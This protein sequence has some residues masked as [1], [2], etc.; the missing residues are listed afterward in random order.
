[1]VLVHVE[2][3]EVQHYLCVVAVRVVGMTKA[4]RS[5][6][7][8]HIS[9][10]LSSSN[11]YLCHF[12]VDIFLIL[13]N[14]NF[15]LP[16]EKKLLRIVRVRKHGRVLGRVKGFPKRFFFEGRAHCIANFLLLYCSSNALSR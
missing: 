1:M 5:F 13:H 6:M 11:L 15:T 14:K 9:L 12:Y 10:L 16:N 4:M 2:T 3:Y 7:R 8:R